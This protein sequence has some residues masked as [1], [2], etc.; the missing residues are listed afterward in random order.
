MVVFNIYRNPNACLVERGKERETGEI[1]E[2]P[3]TWKSGV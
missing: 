3:Y 1:L 2:N